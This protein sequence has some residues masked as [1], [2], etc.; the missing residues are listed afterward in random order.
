MKVLLLPALGNNCLLLVDVVSI[1]ITAGCGSPPAG[2][3]SRER[4]IHDI[5]VFIKPIHARMEVFVLC[6]CGGCS[7]CTGG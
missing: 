7:C 2:S 3:R 1:Y 5:V 4:G 6:T